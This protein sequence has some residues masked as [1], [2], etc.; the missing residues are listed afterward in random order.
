MSESQSEHISTWVWPGPPKEFSGPSKYTR[1]TVCQIPPGSLYFASRKGPFSELNARITGSPY[2]MIGI[3]VWSEAAGREGVYVYTMGMNLPGVVV[4]N[5]DTL[6]S[7]DTII[8][9]AILPLKDLLDEEWAEQ[10]HQVLKELLKKYRTLS[11]QHDSYQCLAS[12]IGLPIADSLRPKKKMTPSELIGLILFQAGLIGDRRNP[13]SNWEKSFFE[14][15]EDGNVTLITPALFRDGPKRDKRSEGST[16]RDERSEGSTYRDESSS[17]SS[18]SSSS[19]PPSPKR[20]QKPEEISKQTE[21][22]TEEV[23]EDF[24]DIMRED[25][26]GYLRNSYKPPKWLE[27]SEELKE[28]GGEHWIDQL[29]TPTQKTIHSQ[30]ILFGSLRPVDFLIDYYSDRIPENHKRVNYRGRCDQLI[31]LLETL[32]DQGIPN[33]NQLDMSWYHD[34]LITI[35]LWNRTESLCQKEVE[36]EIQNL[37]IILAEL[38]QDFIQKRI[39]HFENSLLSKERLGK[40][41]QMISELAAELHSL[42]NLPSTYIRTSENLKGIKEWNDIKSQMRLN[43]GTNSEDESTCLMI[44]PRYMWG[45]GWKYDWRSEAKFDQ[46]EFTEFFQRLEKLES[47]FSD[48]QR[49]VPSNCILLELIVHLQENTKHLHRYIQS[50]HRHKI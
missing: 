12:M 11:P 21:T 9:H 7:D 24:D 20:P 45:Q 6:I 14:E 3:T 48:L 25:L 8:H 34:H 26:R 50:C 27:N 13:I 33:I 28:K 1:E 42:A 43:V 49:R 38:D 18:T 37:R 17:S 35:D 41:C 4:V 5:L 30:T 32:S 19:P 36:N 16:Y 40:I 15:S 2:D 31:A 22:Q 10:R 46:R 23:S 44:L 39:L 29:E 47:R